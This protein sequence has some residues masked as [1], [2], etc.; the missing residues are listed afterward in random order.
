MRPAAS[1]CQLRSI[2]S[3]FYSLDYVTLYWEYE[4]IA[5]VYNGFTLREIG[6]L[7]VRERAY[8]VRMAQYRYKSRT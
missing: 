3:V 1:I 5:T 2:G 7:T 4:A 6:E 8:W